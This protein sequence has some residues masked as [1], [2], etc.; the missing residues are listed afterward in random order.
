MVMGCG[1]GDGDGDG[2]VDDGLQPVIDRTTATV[3]RKEKRLLIICSSK[4]LLHAKYDTHQ[5]RKTVTVFE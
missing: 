5:T 2:G 4:I 3:N 1:D